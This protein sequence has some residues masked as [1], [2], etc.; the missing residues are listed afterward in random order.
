MPAKGAQLERVN[1]N[2]P[3]PLLDDLR[4]LVPRSRRSEV[5]ARATARE[6][7]RLKLAA[8]LE[9]LQRDPA[10]PVEDY[11]A[12]KNEAGIETEMGRL[13]G[14][15]ADAP[16]PAKTRRKGSRERLPA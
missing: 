5:I 9:E 4:R 12:L 11:P 6:L 16:A 1:V 15:P 8:L 10:W 14:N 7:R 3:R 2:L 13:R